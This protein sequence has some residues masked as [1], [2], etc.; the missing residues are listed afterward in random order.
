M[1]LDCIEWL[2]NHLGIRLFVCDHH[3]TIEILKNSKD[4]SV[5]IYK[6][7]MELNSGGSAELTASE[8]ADY[9]LPFVGEIRELL[10][11]NEEIFKKCEDVKNLLLQYLDDKEATA[12]YTYIYV[13]WVKPV[14]SES[15]IVKVTF[16]YFNA[17]YTLMQHIS[18]QCKDLGRERMNNAIKYLCENGSFAKGEEI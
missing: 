2:K 15:Y 3:K 8:Q 9:V 11:E 4:G 6:Q 13:K 12:S 18:G 17:K 14:E 7:M 5:K 16:D 1:V 10:E